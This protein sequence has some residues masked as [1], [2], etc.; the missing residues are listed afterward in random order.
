M[1]GIENLVLVQLRGQRHEGSEASKSGWGENTAAAGR[2]VKGYPRDCYLGKCTRTGAR[3][4]RRTRY[5][6]QLYASLMR[7]QPL[8]D[9]TRCQA[10]A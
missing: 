2:G 9:A 7:T 1:L 8:I 5:R 3:G 6:L 10:E 4:Y